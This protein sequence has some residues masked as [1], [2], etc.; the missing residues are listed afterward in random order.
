MLITQ[1]HLGSDLPDEPGR[2]DAF[3]FRWLSS[4][5]VSAA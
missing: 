4:L 3:P 1:L 2:F 5:A